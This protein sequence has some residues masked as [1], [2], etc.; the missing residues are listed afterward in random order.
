MERAK[1]NGHSKLGLER[2]LSLPSRPSKVSRGTQFPLGDH[3]S[4]HPGSG[5]SPERIVGIFR[6]AEW[7]WPERQCDLFEDILERDAHLRSLEHARISGVASREW[8]VQAGGDAPEDLTAASELEGALRTMPGFVDAVEHQLSALFYGYAGSEIIWE[9]RDGLTA[10]AWFANVPAK[11]FVFDDRDAPRILTED[12]R[13]DGWPLEPGRWWWSRGRHRI[14]AMSGLLRTATWWSLFKSYSVRDLALYIERFGMPYATG[15]Y[16][17]A[18]PPEEREVLRQALASLGKDGYS[19]FDR[20][21]EIKIVELGSD[22]REIPMNG[23]IT[24]CNAELSKLV[25]G[26]TLASGE[27]T[28]A[29]SYALG[30]VHETRLY[31]LWCEDALR[32]QRGF[33]QYV[34]LPFVVFNGMRARAPRLK[35]HLVRDFDPAARMDL[36]V[37]AVNELGI[38]VDLDQVRQEFQLKEPVGEAVPGMPTPAPGGAGGAEDSGGI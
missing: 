25:T 6:N 30:K 22:A 10:P 20:S 33:E 3:W 34:G 21:G 36:I 5:L 15:V 4:S 32:L 38:S 24:L 16:D 7:G 2:P 18:T 14:Q 37:R 13:A 28:S 29:G 26:A 17:A 27:G 31:D 23:M 12:N 1:A 9:R 11:R 8:I 35:I 19:I